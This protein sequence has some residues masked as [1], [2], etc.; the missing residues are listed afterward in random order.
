MCTTASMHW[1]MATLTELIHPQCTQEQMRGI[2]QQAVRTHTACVSSVGHRMLQTRELMDLYPL[3]KNYSTR[4]FFGC[5]G[6]VTAN[7]IA[8]CCVKVGD[9]ARLMTPKSAIVFTANGH[10][11]AVLKNIHGCFHFD[12]AGATVQRLSSPDVD[13]CTVLAAAHRS[14]PPDTDFTLYVIDKMVA[15]AVKEMPDKVCTLPIAS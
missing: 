13:L 2:M 14:M 1:C 11:T 3:P 8:D 6:D 12:P 5:V 9:V 7:D 10:T 4:E 15:S